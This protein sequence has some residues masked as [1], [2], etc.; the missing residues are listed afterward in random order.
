MV[1]ML[2]LASHSVWDGV[3]FRAVTMCN[4]LPLG[5]SLVGD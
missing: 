1:L 5:R 4:A 3:S 2:A